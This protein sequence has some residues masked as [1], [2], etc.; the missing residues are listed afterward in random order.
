M[1]A[2]TVNQCLEEKS[3]KYQLGDAMELA[4]TANIGDSDRDLG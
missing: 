2:H 1:E 4:R 3:Q